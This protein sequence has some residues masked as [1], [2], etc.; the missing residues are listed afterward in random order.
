MGERNKKVKNHFFITGI[1]SAIGNNFMSIIINTL[2]LICGIFV[3]D[4]DITVGTMFAFISYSAYLLQPISLISYLKIIVS[5]IKPEF[6]TYKSFISLEE[7]NESRQ[8]NEFPKSD[9]VNMSF[10]NVSFK[11]H[12][13]SEE[14]LKNI[15]FHIKHLILSYKQEILWL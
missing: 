4:N 15:S 1:D 3:I 2:Y 13:H 11:Y 14:V 5:K 6:E 12:D 9:K 7:E 8:T 10:K